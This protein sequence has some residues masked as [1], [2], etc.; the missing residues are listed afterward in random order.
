MTQPPFMSDGL[1]KIFCL[2]WRSS[3]SHLHINECECKDL[4][5]GVKRTQCDRCRWHSDAKTKPDSMFEIQHHVNELRV[6]TVT[7]KTRSWSHSL[8]LLLLTVNPLYLMFPVVAEWDTTHLCSTLL[9]FVFFFFHCS[10]LAIKHAKICNHSLLHRDEC[11][12]SLITG[13]FAFQR[14]SCFIKPKRI[15]LH[16]FWSLHK[17]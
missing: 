11:N 1:S 16:Y 13:K 14:K 17:C 15:F 7:V 6:V 3:S 12:F 5:T 8:E 9:C 10:L 4:F 2:C